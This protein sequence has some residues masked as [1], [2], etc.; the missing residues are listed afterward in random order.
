MYS[1]YIATRRS[2]PLLLSK[3]KINNKT[4]AAKNVAS[5]FIHTFKFYT[6]KT[7]LFFLFCALSI[8]SIAQCSKYGITKSYAYWQLQ[9][10]GNISTEEDQHHKERDTL[11]IVYIEVSKAVKPNWKNA[12]VGIN[13]YTILQSKVASPVNVGVLKNQSDSTVL[14]AKKKNQIWQLTLENPTPVVQKSEPINS[15]I[16]LKGMWHNKRVNYRIK[17]INELMPVLT[18]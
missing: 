16:K 9:Y 13:K 6:M 4:E 1:L 17:P 12:V 3:N 2:I 18:M 5:F 11:F 15:E 10:P 7:L 8:A 14:N